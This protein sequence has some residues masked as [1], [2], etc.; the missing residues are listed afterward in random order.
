MAK[1]LR[2][3]VVVATY[4]GEKYISEQL[5]S[6]IHQLRPGDELI[7]TDDGSSD[8]TLDIVRE[9]RADGIEV[10]IL[11]GPKD[12]IISNF[13][14]GIQHASNEIIFL[15]DQDDVWSEN[16]VDTILS[17]FQ[18][19]PGLSCVLHDVIVVDEKLDVTNA[20]FF[21]YRNS[22]PGL[23]QNII[24]NSFMGSAM[25]F[26]AE[27]RKYILPIPREIAMHD[28]W[29]GLICSIFGKTNLLVEQLGLYRRHD[30]NASSFE[31]GSI[32]Q[33]LHNRF[34]LL[35]YLINRY[36]KIHKV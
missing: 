17:L 28:Q 24:K 8:G 3:S 34:V 11:S 31:H 6:I 25:A 13:E 7:V 18:H 20:S 5:N 15:A 30:N 1:S 14:N 35:F 22:R 23:I 21:Q 12:G 4:N 33:M 36:I 16:K 2:A 19:D 9:M 10:R 32:A 29:I 27:M 26:R